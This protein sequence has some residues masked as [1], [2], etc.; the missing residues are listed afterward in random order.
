MPY[1]ITS[2]T[3]TRDAV[4]PVLDTNIGIVDAD[5]LHSHSQSQDIK[6]G[7]AKDN[8]QTFGKVT[9]AECQRVMW[10][11]TVDEPKSEWPAACQ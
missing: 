5:N 9:R 8:C 1:A 6:T 7:N 3:K 10:Q 2:E 4:V 11:A